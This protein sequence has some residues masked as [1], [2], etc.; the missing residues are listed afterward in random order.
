[1]YAEAQPRT[2]AATFP[3]TPASAPVDA[4]FAS[5]VRSMVA[6]LRA[7][8]LDEAQAQYEQL[9]EVDERLRDMLVFPVLIA[10]QR[11]QS[12]EALQYLNGLPGDPHPELRALCLRIVG[13]PTWHGEA[14]ALVDAPDP[15]IARAMR[16]LLAGADLP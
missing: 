4:A 10:I 5:E 2:V 11:G 13:D 14:A 15:Y 9:C 3:G 1:M 6:H 8:R 12:L 16:R 7:N